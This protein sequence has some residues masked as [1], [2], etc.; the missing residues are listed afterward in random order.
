[1]VLLMNYTITS[2]NLWV[3]YMIKVDQQFK[4][5]VSKGEHLRY[6]TIDP[7]FVI[8]GD[9]D[10]VYLDIDS[11]F[12]ADTNP[13]DV[14]AFSDS[15]GKNI[16]ATFDEM[17]GKVFNIP[18]AKR[19]IVNTE[20]EAVSD[21]SVFFGKK[22]YSMHVIDMEGKKVD[23]LKQMGL[24]IIKSDTPVVIQNFLQDIVNLML[25][26]ATYDDIKKVVGDFKE[27]YYTMTMTQIGRPTNI[28]VLNKY[29]AK[30]QRQLTEANKRDTL[31]GVSVED[32]DPMK[33]LPYHAKAAIIYN[34]M[35]GTNDV[36]I[37]AGDKMRIT[38]VKDESFKAIGI[39]ADLEDHEIPQFVKDMQID[40]KVMWDKVVNKL[41]NYLVPIGYDKKARVV[42]QTT[43]FF[44]GG[45]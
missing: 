9:T 22:K 25:D 2:E 24:E 29:Y 1:M 42:A 6:E 32:S 34:M 43:K 8:A 13:D 27:V 18:K 4:M 35:C 38:Y 40:Y 26:H 37:R 20:R 36:E 23:K 3:V 45:S 17:L 14:V 30:F 11:L 16:N 5:F 31:H 44:F 15:L 10:S 39:P 19:H 33:G 12:D 21:K 28:K 7:E 41:D